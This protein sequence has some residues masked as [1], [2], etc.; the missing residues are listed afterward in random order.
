MGRKKIEIEKI[1]SLKPR[2][3]TFSKR[4]AGLFNK[5]QVQCTLC[6][7]ETTIVVFSPGGRV[8]TFGNPNVLNR[9][10]AEYGGVEDKVEVGLEGGPS[11]EIPAGDVTGMQDR[12]KGEDKTEESKKN[13]F[14]SWLDAPMDGLS[15]EELE[16][17]KKV[18]EELLAKVREKLSK[19]WLSL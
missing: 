13:S 4:R 15:I 6:G 10:V 11:Q 14:K 9:F 3:V 2:Q 8:F 18:V 16:K 5:A 17:E 19:T 1:Q 12:K 7:S